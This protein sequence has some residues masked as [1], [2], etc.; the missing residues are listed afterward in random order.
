MKE[1]DKNKLR[2]AIAKEIDKGNKKITEDNFVVH[3]DQFDDA[4]NYLIREGYLS[5]IFHA[6]NRPWFF[7]GT[8]Y[9]TAAGENYLR[10]LTKLNI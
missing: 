2:Y 8:A 9:L 3:A 4:V 7:E 10:D 6:D 1:I 5:G